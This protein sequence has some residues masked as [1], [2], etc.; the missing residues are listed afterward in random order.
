[1]MIITASQGNCP[2]RCAHTFETTW[3]HIRPG[4]PA[5]LLRLTSH[6]PD[7][8][9]CTD[10]GKAHRRENQREGLPVTKVIH[11]INRPVNHKQTRKDKVRANIGAEITPACCKGCCK[12]TESVGGAQ[13]RRRLGRSDKVDHVS[14]VALRPTMIVGLTTRKPDLRSSP[15]AR[16]GC[17]RIAAGHKDRRRSRIPQRRRASSP[18][19][20]AT[21]P[22]QPSDRD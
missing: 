22:A 8:T 13:R 9:Q 14:L 4:V 12:I 7:S 2:R 18:S 11:T 15:A 20:C 5:L 17:S 10:R 1:M 6:E 19:P 21:W 16:F 3:D